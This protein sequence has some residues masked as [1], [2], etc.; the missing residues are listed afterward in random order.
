MLKG[1]FVER[2]FELSGISVLDIYP[3]VIKLTEHIIR[4]KRLESAEFIAERELVLCV[5]LKFTHK[6]AILEGSPG[7]RREL[8]QLAALAVGKVL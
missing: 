3:V 8:R 2:I 7:K 6:A 5:G 1:F 4:G